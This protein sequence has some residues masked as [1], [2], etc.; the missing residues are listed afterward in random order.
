MGA[1]LLV[2][3]DG[4]LG[5]AGVVAFARMPWFRYIVSTDFVRLAKP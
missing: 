1:V 5:V 3:G 2:Q 4:G